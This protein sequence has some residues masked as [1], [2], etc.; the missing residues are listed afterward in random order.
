M[1][2]PEIFVSYRRND[3]SARAFISNLEAIYG[4]DRVFVDVDDLRPGVAFPARIADA[5]RSSV[6]VIAAIGP[7]W[8]TPR[9]QPGNLSQE[10]D[11]IVQ[12][13]VYAQQYVR[14]V[15]PVLL[16]E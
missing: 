13:L 12:E 6:V 8:V 7:S 3:P 11:W 9:W 4:P 1:T 10:E 14:Q 2:A 16:G 5:I 15:L